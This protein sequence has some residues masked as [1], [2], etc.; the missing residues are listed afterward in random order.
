MKVTPHGRQVLRGETTPRLLQPTT[1]KAAASS[2]KAKSAVDDRPYDVG[3]FEHLR[4]LRRELAET[5]GIPP[6]MVFG[7]VTLRDLARRRP[8]TPEA[9]GEV[10]GVGERKAAEY[11]DAFQFAIAEYCA[12]H[13]VEANIAMISEPVAVPTPSREKDPS[14]RGAAQ[15]SADALFRQGMSVED[16][17]TKLGRALSTT[18]AYLVDFLKFDGRTSPEP[19]LDAATFNRIAAVA[20]ECTDDRLKPLFD[21]FEGTV[22]YDAL[23]IA[24]TCVRNRRDAS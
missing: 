24:M 7:D 23:R 13:Q 8:T 20:T 15:S 16:V 22:S 12:E 6:F 17:A 1:K 14:E 21:H 4:Q 9:F 18:Q 5:K 11:G 2:T 3:L 19:W 10:H